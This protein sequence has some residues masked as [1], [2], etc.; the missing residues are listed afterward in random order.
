MLNIPQTK[1]ISSLAKSIEDI[2][3]PLCTTINNIPKD[4]PSD[5]EKTVLSLIP[6]TISKLETTIKKHFYFKNLTVKNLPNTYDCVNTIG[7]S[8]YLNSLKTKT[9]LTMFWRK[10]YNSEHGSIDK[11]NDLSTVTDIS[12]QNDSTDKKLVSNLLVSEIGIDF[13]GFLC[14]ETKVSPEIKNVNSSELTAAIL[15]ELGHL[16]DFC[17][18]VVTVKKSFFMKN[19]HFNFFM[20]NASIEEK[21]GFIKKQLK[22]IQKDPHVHL[23]KNELEVAEKLPEILIETKTDLI[24]SNLFEVEKKLTIIIT[25][26][27]TLCAFIFNTIFAVSFNTTLDFIIRSFKIDNTEHDDFKFTKNQFSDKEFNADAFVAKHGYGNHLISILNKKQQID[28]YPKNVTGSKLAYKIQ[29]MCNVIL[30]SSMG[31]LSDTK[32]YVYKNNLDRAKDIRNS[33]IKV[34]K[35]SDIS[36]DMLITFLNS[37]KESDLY[38]EEII[39]NRKLQTLFNLYIKTLSTIIGSPYYLI[40]FI[41]VGTEN[42]DISNLLDNIR[43]LQNND[44]Y[45]YSAELKTLK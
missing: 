33:T 6:T 29:M 43:T 26:I 5:R 39:K 7:Y 27:N 30:L 41:M 4:R 17:D 24:K 44:L 13:V 20:K 3:S 36:D 37:I 9:E 1:T 40:S 21:V 8:K 14:C 18:Q 45:I 32:L 38:I 22:T 2:I 15:H 11:V 10:K 42:K 25:L 28:K 34:L 19:E 12:I 23:S 31:E 35:N 16:D